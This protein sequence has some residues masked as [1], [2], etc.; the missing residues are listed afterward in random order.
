MSEVKITYIKF[1]V[2]HTV[3]KR[4]GLFLDTHYTI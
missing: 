3:G 1:G 2:M 4:G